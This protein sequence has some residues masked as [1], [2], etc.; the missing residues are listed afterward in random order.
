[1]DFLICSRFHAHIYS[2]ICRKPFISLSCSRKC[3]N[4][5][6]ENKL[7]NLYYRLE[8]NDMGIPIN[9]DAEDIT[10]FILEKIT[11]GDNIS[12][13]LDKTMTKINYELDDFIHYWIEFIKLNI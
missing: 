7:Y 6:K 5:I 1:M 4:L 3:K 11:S 8:T 9:L 12:K 10:L 13:R 2:M